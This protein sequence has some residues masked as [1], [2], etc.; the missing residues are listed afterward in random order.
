[1]KIGDL[2]K[3]TDYHDSPVGL[4]LNVYR[5]LQEYKEC[6]P[7]WRELVDIVWQGQTNLSTHDTIEIEV[8]NGRC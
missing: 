1:M 4:V 6:K 8:V 5:H 3:Y 2:V 7:F